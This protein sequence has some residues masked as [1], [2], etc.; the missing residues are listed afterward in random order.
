[1]LTG[2]RCDEEY[3]CAH[4]TATGINALYGT[5]AIQVVTR[6]FRLNQKLMECH[7][8]GLQVYTSEELLHTSEQFQP[9]SAD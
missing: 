2:W 1:M 5:A 7:T 3:L 4:W 8:H 6:G 9:M